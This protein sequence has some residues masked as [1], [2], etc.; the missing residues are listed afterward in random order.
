M[1]IF[2][3]SVHNLLR[4][5]IIIAM[6][7]VIFRAFRGLFSKID[8]TPMDQRIQLILT[9]LLDSQALLGIMIYVFTSSLTRTIFTDFQSVMSN[10]A[11][12]YFGVE[13][14]TLM[15]LGV[16][17]AHIGSI[18]SKRGESSAKKFR[19]SVIWFTLSLILLLG[20]IPWPF[21]TYG[22]PW[23]PF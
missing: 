8:W 23:L 22:R 9:I 18:R 10:P 17:F 12:R 1:H 14:V 6:T 15:I 16:I 3:L 5:A 21:L 11:L 7:I 2:L 20:G 13:H 19:Q 4:W